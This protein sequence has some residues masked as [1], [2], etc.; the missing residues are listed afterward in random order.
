MGS[1]RPLALALALAPGTPEVA[2][3]AG[4]ASPPSP[5]GCQVLARLLGPMMPNV[6]VFYE[7]ARRS[8][9]ASRRGGTA[10]CETEPF[11]IALNRFCQQRNVYSIPRE[12]QSPNVKACVCARVNAYVH[13]F[14][15][16]VSARIDCLN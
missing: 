5:R 6:W 16:C 1:A 4:P 8:S 7:T 9:A 14:V 10:V 13:V 11:A 3:K 12:P 2:R 15:G